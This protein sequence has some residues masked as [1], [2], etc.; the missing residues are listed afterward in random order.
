METNSDIFVYISPR[1]C[2]VQFFVNKFEILSLTHHRFKQFRTEQKTFKLVFFCCC[3]NQEIWFD[4]IRIST[5]RTFPWSARVSHQNFRQG[6]ARA[7]VRGGTFFT[8]QRANIFF[9]PYP[10]WEHCAHPGNPL[11]WYL[12]ND[13]H[14]SILQY[15]FM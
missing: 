4:L 8:R 10:P 14:T 9:A 12:F 6:H 3:Y 2:A 13:I 7:F 1:K 11:F 5:L 15:F